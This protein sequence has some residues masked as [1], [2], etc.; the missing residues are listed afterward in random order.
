[1]STSAVPAAIDALLT[2]CRTSPS[3]ADVAISDG[4]V[5]TDLSEP[6]RL[7]I[8]WAPEDTTAATSVQDFASAGARRRDEDFAILGYVESRSGDTDLQARRT[9]VYQVLAAIET[10]LR[11]TDAQPDAPTLNQTVLWAHLTDTAL[12]Q[13][14]TSDGALAGIRFTVTCRARL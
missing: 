12:S 3:L 9:R 10:L 1:M 14:Q 6:D 4:P 13:P 7:F 5:T 8:G 11:A 2:L